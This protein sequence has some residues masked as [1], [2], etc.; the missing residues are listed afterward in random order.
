MASRRREIET[1]FGGY[2][3]TF[4]ETDRHG[5]EWLVVVIRYLHPWAA[6]C[7]DELGKLCGLALAGGVLYWL[8]KQNITVW[9]LW[10]VLPLVPVSLNRQWGLL[11]RHLLRFRATVRLS[12]DGILVGRETLD[13]H[14]V[15]GFEL[16]DD[17]DRMHEERRTAQHLNRLAQQPKAKPLKPRPLYHGERTKQIVCVLS[18][19]MV[20]ICTV[21]GQQDFLAIRKRLN[22]INDA[23][24]GELGAGIGTPMSASADTPDGRGGVPL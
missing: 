21:F 6:R 14:Q 20:R 17:F 15:R 5:T 24:N 10:I 7:A 8:Y 16:L 4:V 2:P 9:W 11:L 22:G 1:T 12:G 3:E 19:R 18:G 13:R 23:L